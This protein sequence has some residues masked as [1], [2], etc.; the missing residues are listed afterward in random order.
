M[1]CGDYV[2][3]N[4]TASFHFLISSLPTQDDFI[5]ADKI[6]KDYKFFDYFAEKLKKE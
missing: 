4:P 5:V 6:V 1:V 3:A 2:G